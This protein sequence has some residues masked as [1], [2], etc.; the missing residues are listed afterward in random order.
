MIYWLEFDIFVEDKLVSHFIFLPDLKF[1]LN[2]SYY[3]Q[4][5]YHFYLV[6]NIVN[7]FLLNFTLIY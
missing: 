4:T 6:S 7:R 2:I 3:Y 1:E 5:H